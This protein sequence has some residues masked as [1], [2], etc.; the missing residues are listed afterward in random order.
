MPFLRGDIIPLQLRLLD[1]R[2]PDPTNPNSGWR[3]SVSATNNTWQY[4]AQLLD[5][6]CQTIL[7]DVV[8]DFCSDWW[9]SFDPEFGSLQTLFIDTDKLPLSQEIFRIA[10]QRRDPL[11][12]VVESLITEVFALS[13]CE[14]SIA[15]ESS[16][17][18]VDCLR[19]IYR[20]A[21]PIFRHFLPPNYQPTAFYGFIRLTGDLVLNN[22]A[23]EKIINDNNIVTEFRQLNQYIAKLYPIAPFAAEMLAAIASA[24]E[25]TANGLAFTEMSDVEKGVDSGTMFYPSPTLTR[26][27]ET[28]NLPC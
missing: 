28:S 3:D 18:Q 21:G 20:I 8:D 6:D 7:S 2:S 5:W 24:S 15:F 12:V 10:I 13:V 11:G 26:V 17:P 25:I 19:R 27:C 23:T 22:L 4:R 1:L 16:V 14:P 9:I